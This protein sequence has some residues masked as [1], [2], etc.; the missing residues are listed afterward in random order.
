[1]ATRTIQL[2]SAN[3]SAGLLA[4]ELVDSQDVYNDEI[5]K[6]TRGLFSGNAASLSSFY[7]SSAQSASSGDYYYD[8]YDKVGSD[9]TREI[10]F[11]VAYGHA[12]GSGSLKLNASSNFVGSLDSPSR[13]IYAQYQQTLLPANTTKFNFTG[14]GTENSIYAINFKRSRLKDK[15]DPG[16]WEVL[17]GNLR[18]IDD[19]GDTGQTTTTDREYYN[20]VSGSL[21][22]GVYTPSTTLTYGRV[23]PK[24]GIIVLSG[25]ALDASASMNTTLAS[26]QNGDNALKLF[27]KIVAGASFK[28]RSLEEVKSSYYFLRVRNSRFNFSNNPS[29]I[30]TGSNGTLTFSQPTF[31]RDPK[32]YITTVGLFNSNNEMLAVGKLSQPILKSYANEILLKVKLDF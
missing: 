5:Q 1:M 32:T 13:A 15:L 9:S 16:N 10:Q 4:Y 25:T 23:Y 29:F 20:V 6:I 14:V 21:S 18:L 24:R 28:A 17:V 27:N 7:T 22:S 3:I 11:S 26:N 8:V 30:S 31:A 12:L 19:S 2:G